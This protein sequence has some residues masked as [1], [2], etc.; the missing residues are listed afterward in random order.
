MA[1][2]S[3]SRR[4]SAKIT[5]EFIENFDAK[6][7]CCWIAEMDGERVGS[8]FVV[9]KTDEVA[10]LRLVIVDPKARGLGLGKRLVDECLRFAKGAGYKSMTLWT[11]D[12]L[13][14][15]RGIYERAGFKL[16]ASEPNHRFGVDLIS[17][18]W[19]RDL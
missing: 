8:A 15:A 17:E 18:T 6:R 7:E 5:A 14:A 4:W 10:K 13:Y 16:V 3:R 1:G 19:E 2:T 9:R 12:Y 11:Q